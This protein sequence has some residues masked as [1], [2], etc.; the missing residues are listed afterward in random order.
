MQQH[1]ALDSKQ[2]SSIALSRVTGGRRSRPRPRLVGIFDD[3]EE[4][5]NDAV[6]ENLTKTYEYKYSS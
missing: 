5:E 6:A 2:I 3:E 1:A 4:D